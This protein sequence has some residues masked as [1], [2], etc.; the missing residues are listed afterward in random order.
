MKR[1]CRTPA[2][3]RQ[4]KTTMGSCVLSVSLQKENKKHPAGQAIQAKEGMGNYAMPCVSTN[5]RGGEGVHVAD[6]DLTGSIH[7]VSCPI[8]DGNR[9]SRES[10]VA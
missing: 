2:V 8:P 5:K 3:T 9:A 6:D 1:L 4:G 10:V 7:G